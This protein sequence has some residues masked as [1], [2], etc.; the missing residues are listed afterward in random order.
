LRSWLFLPPIT[1]IVRTNVKRI[2]W[3]DGGVRLI[4]SLQAAKRN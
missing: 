4:P 2:A 1:L 3:A